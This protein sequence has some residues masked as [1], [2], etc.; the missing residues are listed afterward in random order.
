[1][2]AAGEVSI[3][4]L[5]GS[6]ANLSSGMITLKKQQ[7]KW[8][9]LTLCFQSYLKETLASAGWT[10]ARPGKA[11][12]EPQLIE[13]WHCTAGL[14]VTQQSAISSRFK[15]CSKAFGQWSKRK[16]LLTSCD[17]MLPYLIGCDE[18]VYILKA[19][20]ARNKASDFIQA[21]GDATVS[22]ISTN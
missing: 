9:F 7:Q 19:R 11:L 17:L 13:V 22:Q 6:K 3:K 18:K 10:Q 4:W 21:T 16:R 15:Y 20:S 2:S 5:H 1:M 12:L 8:D 14:Q